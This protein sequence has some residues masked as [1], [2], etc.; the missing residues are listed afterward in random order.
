MKKIITLFVGC[1]LIIGCS[2]SKN[3]IKKSF[4]LE[5]VK[6]IMNGDSLKPMRVYKINNKRDSLLL[7]TKSTYIKPPGSPKLTKSPFT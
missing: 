6:L 5:E 2:S 1:L 3:S 7:R 4:S